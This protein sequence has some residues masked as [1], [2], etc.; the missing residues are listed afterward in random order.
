MK[1]IGFVDYY[2]SEWHANNY[3]VWI[4]EICKENNKDFC[5]KYAWAEK[6]ISPVDGL[7]TAEWCEKFGIDKCETIDELCQKSDYIIILAPSDPEKHLE[8]AKEVLKYGKYTYIDKTFTPDFAQAKEIFGLA[9]KYNTKIFST[10]ALRY[11]TE[12]DSLKGAKNILTTGGGSNL[13]EYMV[14]QIE[15]AVKLADEKP[16]A[17]K[18]EKQGNQCIMQV[19]FENEKNAAMIYS[20]VLSFSV[21]TDNN[22]EGAFKSIESDF[23]KALMKD[24]I[25][26][27]ETGECSFD[28]AQTLDI[29]KIR[30]ALLSGEEKLGQWI[31]L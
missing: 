12:L 4:E 9:E 20:P 16:V 2:I 1:T 11:A 17:V 3:P 13:A 29:M 27:F 31:E 25:C 14:H 28:T 26:F 22:G 21:C 7:S 5:V 10:S 6:D 15:I 30:E 24:I 19:R 23:F 18:L 8:Y